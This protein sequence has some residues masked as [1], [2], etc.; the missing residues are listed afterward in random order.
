MRLIRTLGGSEEGEPKERVEV[1]Q[2]V[3]FSPYHITVISE[4]N[5]LKVRDG[6]ALL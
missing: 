1:E 5:T 3:L 6:A 4:C 2:R